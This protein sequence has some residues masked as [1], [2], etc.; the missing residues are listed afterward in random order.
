MRSQRLASAA[1]PER[2]AVHPW[3]ND[4]GDDPRRERHA[5]DEGRH[6]HPL[7]AGLARRRRSV[8]DR[9]TRRDSRRDA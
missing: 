3:R 8:E 7:R 6:E 1:S 2:G 5:G 4:E 9:Q